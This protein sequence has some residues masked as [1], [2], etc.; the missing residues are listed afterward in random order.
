MPDVARDAGEKDRGVTAF[1]AAHHRH[2]GNGMTL[3]EIFPE[4]ERV[5][6]GGVPAHNY[7]L[8]VVG[9]NLRLDEVAWTEKIGDRPGL[10][11]GAQRLFLKSLAVFEIGALQFFATERRNLAVATQSEVLRHI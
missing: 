9:K 11:H 6:A 5:D 3:P 1:K 7:V 10:A 8:I 2:F 4:K